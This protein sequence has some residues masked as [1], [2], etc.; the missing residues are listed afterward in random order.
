MMLL[1]KR[2]LAIAALLSILPTPA[3]GADYAVGLKAYD[4]GDFAAALAEWLPLAKDGDA[5]AQHGIALLYET[6]RGVPATDDIEAAKWYAEAALQGIAESQAN[7]AL[8]FAE[9]RGVE[10]DYARAA[11][12]WQQA[13]AKGNAVAHY[14]LG[15]LH[16]NGY[17]VTEDAAKAAGWFEKAAALK[18]V[19]A[20]YAI[21]RLYRAGQGVPKDLVKARS[22]YQQA[23]G[24]G[25]SLAAAELAALEAELA[26]APAA[27]E[28]AVEPPQGA[29]V[30]AP[31]PQPEPESLTP[32]PAAVD[33]AEIAS[34]A[35]VPPPA[36]TD[37]GAAPESSG[38]LTEL[39]EAEVEPTGPPDDVIADQPAAV[40][41]TEPQAEP[42]TPPAAVADVA[43]LEAGEAEPP[44]A[45][46]DVSADPPAVAE[47]AAPQAPA[48]AA[49]PAASQV[50]AVPTVHIWLSS[51]E[52]REQAARGWDELRTA[53]PDLLGNLELTIREVDLGAEKGTWYRIY[54]GPMA[55][56]NEARA[57]CDRI[58][59][60]PP[61]SDCLVAAD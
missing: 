22:W 24:A 61:N 13:A 49:T 55:D 29:A 1:L 20:Q 25:H 58:K 15:L 30:P 28:V 50:A 3:S 52:T 8:M 51:Q 31:E 12:L 59:A 48:A 5:K 9:G 42:E 33:T 54:A 14:N 34:P 11:D 39:G 36:A 57:L 37:V 46:V 38:D 35:A 40:A 17:G 23:A 45:A 2:M 16:L 18:V 7:L 56:K 60:Q 4:G 44:V 21:A 32:A 26:V 47:A 6:G 10:Q 53:Y 41:A 43:E 27:P 19:D